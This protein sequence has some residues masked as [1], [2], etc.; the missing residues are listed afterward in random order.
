MTEALAPFAAGVATQ[1]SLQGAFPDLARQ[2]LAL[3]RDGAE[4]DG[5]GSRLVDFLA[6]QTGARSLTPREGADPDAVLSRA[7]F[8]LGEGR[9]ADALAEIRA[10]DP[11]L[12]APFDPW[13]TQAEARLA[14][15]AALEG[16]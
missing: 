4:A 16:R 9:L 2:V 6:A 15:L 12:R 11:A 13:V 14:A 8:A 5:W 1:D 3:A 7:E 10:L